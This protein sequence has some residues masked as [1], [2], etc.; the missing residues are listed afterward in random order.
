MKTIQIEG[1]RSL[2]RIEVGSGICDIER[3]LE[4]R[5]AVIVTDRH[6]YAEYSSLFGDIPAILMGCGEGEKTLK[7]LE[8]LVSRLLEL[9]ADRKTFILGFG[10]GIVCD[11]AGF[12]ASS[13]MRGVDFGFVSTSLLSMVDAS[14]GGKN[15]VNCAGFKNIV[16]SF[17]QPEF[18]C[19]DIDLLSTLPGDELCSG[20][21]EIVKHCLIADEPMLTWLEQN[22]AKA[23][24]LDPYVMEK[25]VL[26]SVGIKAAVV[27]RDEKESG[28]R[29]TLNLGH[30]FGHALEACGAFSRHGEAVSAGIMV[31]AGLS[32]SAGYL[33]EADLLRIKRVLSSLNLPV[34]VPDVGESVFRAMY[35]D[36]KREGDNIHAVLLK[37]LGEAVVE[38]V[39]M[40]AFEDAVRRCVN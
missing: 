11:V 16:G 3:L 28:E 1:G 39:P 12:L 13:Y 25:L 37:R 34:A 6:L 19:C 32:R 36:K 5:R 31:A 21:A 22:A 23:L 15:G 2:S 14:V 26:H 7:T 38:E 30:T 4:N 24:A 20:F 29:R 9:S 10:G 33:N 8:N 18:V 40:K 17:N 27:N 35:S